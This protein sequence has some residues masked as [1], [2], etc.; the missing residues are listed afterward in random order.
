ML[1]WCSY[2]QNFLGEVAPF[3][4]L[5]VTHG[6]CATCAPTA[7]D[8]SDRDIAHA[9]LLHDIQ[10]QLREAGRRGDLGAAEQIVEA[11]RVAGLR[12]V[13]TLIGL[14]TPLLCQVGE[15]WKRAATSVAEEHRFT[16]FCESLYDLIAMRVAPVVV[17]DSAGL[18]WTDALLVNAGGNRHTLGVRLLALWL[19]GKGISALVAPP[20]SSPQEIVT[21]VGAKQPRLVMISMALAE[22]R[23]AV[24]LLVP[25]IVALPNDRRPR[26]LV[27]GYAVKLGQ[28]V[29]IPGAEFVTDLTAL[30]AELWNQPILSQ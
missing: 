21:W 17:A 22:Q 28:V 26:I 10:S 11:A 27:G 8:L 12:P 6:M 29:P 18:A 9:R 23:Q 5:D 19:L 30:P 13:D 24:A 15:D 14:I 7:L 2:C 20:D 16:A 1:K 25:R 3:E 4:Q